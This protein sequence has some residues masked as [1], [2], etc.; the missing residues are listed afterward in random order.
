MSRPHHCAAAD[1]GGCRPGAQRFCSTCGHQCSSTEVTS[2]R[3]LP[4]QQLQFDET[5][6]KEL[7]QVLAADAVRRL[8]Q[9]EELDL[10]PDRLLRMRWVLTWKTPKVETGRQKRGWSFW[11][12]STQKLRVYRQQHQH[13]ERCFV[14]CYFKH[15][16]CTNFGSILE[17]FSQPSCK[18]LP[19]KSIKS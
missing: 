5:M 13:M 16:P 6:T 2:H 15:A 4:G 8:T 1:P 11:D 10:K 9:E 3:L 14:I 12:I 19:R 17:R 7:S 18:H